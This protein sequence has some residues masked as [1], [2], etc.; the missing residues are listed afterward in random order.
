[1]SIY[2]YLSSLGVPYLKFQNLVTLGE[3]VVGRDGQE[4]IDGAN[5]INANLRELLWRGEQARED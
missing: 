2:A 1:M 5:D 3:R 4:E